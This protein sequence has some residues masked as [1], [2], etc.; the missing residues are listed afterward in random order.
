MPQNNKAKLTQKQL[1][2]IKRMFMEYKDISKIAR[3][4]GVARST[5]SYH[6]NQNGWSAE[7]KLQESDVFQAFSDSKKVDFIKMTEHSV[8][9][10][11]KALQH[12]ASRAEPPSISE[13]TKSADILKTLDNILRL[14]E[15]KP[16]D[17][18]A[19]VDKPMNE[20]EIRDKLKKDPF[21]NFEEEE[22]E[23]SN[24]LN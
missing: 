17:I 4:F 6:I 1:A 14:D 24:K 23:E 19:E 2:T 5:I 21:S 22:D 13:A 20:K 8:V 7:R 11:S 16:T 12:L 10:L 18:T 15:G 3:E 9:I